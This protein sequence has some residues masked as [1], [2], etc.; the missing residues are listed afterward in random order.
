MKYASLI[1][2]AILLLPSVSRRKTDGYGGGFPENTSETSADGAFSAEA[3]FPP[4]RPMGRLTE[5]VGELAE[6]CE[7]ELLYADKDTYTALFDGKQYLLKRSAVR[8]FSCD[9]TRLPPVSDGEI[10]R[11]SAL[12]CRAVD[13]PYLLWVDLARLESYLLKRSEGAWQLLRR[14][15]CSA[16]DLAHPTPRGLFSVSSHRPSLGKED[17]YRAVYALHLRDDYFLHSV[18]LSPE[19]NEISDG[20]LGTRVSHGCIRHSVEDSRYLYR[21]LPDGAA[22]LIR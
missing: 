20:R 12:F 21:T 9:V 3:L 17:K 2:C 11:A 1:L 4:Y 15:P 16:G 5:A 10:E 7:L 8:P 22:V 14:L 6:G 18:L 13:S 19:G